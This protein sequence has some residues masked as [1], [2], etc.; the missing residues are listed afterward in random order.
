MIRNIIKIVIS[1]LA[2]AGLIMTLGILW[3]SLL[4][5]LITVIWQ[6][7]VMAFLSK[8]HTLR[9]L[10]RKPWIIF[11]GHGCYCSPNWGYNHPTGDSPPIDDLDIAC[12]THDVDLW[13]NKQALAEG[14]ITQEQ[15]RKNIHEADKAFMTEAM[16]SKNWAIG[17]H[18]LG[19]LIGFGF[20]RLM[21]QI[22]RLF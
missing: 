18:L 1:V 12:Y 2:I 7:S 11:T 6:L 3:G 10:L 5:L 9:H 21:Y 20:R 8:G 16:A 19:M 15:F 17:T 4:A 22:R 14:V 13:E